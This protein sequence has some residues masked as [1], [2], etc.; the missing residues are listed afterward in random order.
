MTKKIQA[1][2]LFSLALALLF[3]GAALAY[4][5]IVDGE[6]SEWNAQ[7][8]IEWT[9]S[10]GENLAT[11]DEF[12]HV[13]LDTL[14]A[15]N[16][17]IN[18]Y[19]RVDTRE[20][21]DW[22]AIEALAFCLDT[23]PDTNAGC[24]LT[25]GCQAAADFAVVV[26]PLTSSAEVIDAATC[27]LAG[28]AAPSVASATNITELGV[29]LATLGISQANCDPGCYVKTQVFLDSGNDIA[30]RD[31]LPDDALLLDEYVWL[32]VGAD[33]PTALNILKFDADT[34]KSGDLMTWT[35]VF[36]AAATLVMLVVVFIWRR[37]LTSPNN[38]N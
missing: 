9:D 23:K 11:Y 30:D 33:S 34:M 1:A 5:I 7:H 19:L 14:W 20:N 21:T 28:G 22:E 31:L 12:S 18:L 13:D 25:W 35:R 4:V 15:T 32:R 38:R 29:P 26:K 10:L 3:S 6:G 24:G 8:M 16:D 17:G 2:L 27:D 37:A 36:T